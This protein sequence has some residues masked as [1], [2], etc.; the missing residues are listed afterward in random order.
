MSQ[1][2]LNPE[3]PKILLQGFFFYLNL[4]Y[5]RLSW[6]E[7]SQS[8]IDI[9][10]WCI[11]VHS[12]EH[13][14]NKGMW[15]YYRFHFECTEKMTVMLGK[16]ISWQMSLYTLHNARPL[17]SLLALLLH[18]STHISDQSHYANL[19]LKIS[20]GLCKWSALI[21]ISNYRCVCTCVYIS[22][23]PWVWWGMGRRVQLLLLYSC[24]GQWEGSLG[25]SW[26]EKGVPYCIQRADIHVSL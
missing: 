19:S 12:A 25:S 4:L 3:Y 22:I 6:M 8:C 5:T 17:C 13:T 1:N 24:L 7:C 18:T 21:N 2:I 20:E 16:A 9:R 10:L 14:V 11:V 26:W 23:S 15:W